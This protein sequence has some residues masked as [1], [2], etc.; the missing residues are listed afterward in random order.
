MLVLLFSAVLL[1]L[2]LV[3]YF[4]FLPPVAAPAPIPVAASAVKSHHQ[5]VTV[6]A[7]SIINSPEV[8]AAHPAKTERPHVEAA[9]VVEM[10]VGKNVKTDNA[11]GLTPRPVL[12]PARGASA[13]NSE[14]HIDSI[15]ASVVS[16]PRYR[17]VDGPDKPFRPGSWLQVE[18]D[19]TTL[20]NVIRELTL[21]Y[22]IALRGET[23]G[24]TIQHADLAQGPH[25][26]VAYLVPRRTERFLVN[27]KLPERVLES[28]TITAYIRDRLVAQGEIGTLSSANREPLEGFIRSLQQTPFF[29]LEADRYEPVAPPAP[30]KE[31]E[32]RAPQPERTPSFTQTLTSRR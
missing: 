19:F 3:V 22:S 20:P 27:G 14:V 24:G 4:T 21:H 6:P 13:E 29:P 11:A 8:N 25:R 1:A 28:V 9:Q 15:I 23:F 10:Q 2:V 17:L 7:D 30:P 32:K 16:S 26:S 31:K 12:V 5:A 18:V